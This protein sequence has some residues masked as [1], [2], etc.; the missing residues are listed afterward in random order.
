VA[1]AEHPSAAAVRQAVIETF[2][3]G[4]PGEAKI[5]ASPLPQITASLDANLRRTFTRVALICRGS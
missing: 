5:A 3:D 2:G 1:V 4:D